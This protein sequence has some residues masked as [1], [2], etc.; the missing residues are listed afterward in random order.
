MHTFYMSMECDCGETILQR[1]ATTDERDGQPVIPFDMPAQ[2]KWECNDCSRTHWTGDFADQVHTE[3]ND[4]DE[5]HT[6]GGN[7][8]EDD[9]EGVGRG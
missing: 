8:D 4:E 7:E 6:E 3:G 1:M 9:A 5:V 2:T